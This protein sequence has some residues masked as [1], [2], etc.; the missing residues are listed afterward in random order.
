MPNN[1]MLS[2]KYS[3]LGAGVFAL[4][5]C[6]VAVSGFGVSSTSQDVSL[7]GSVS[8]NP[9][10]KQV[11]S[12]SAL[13]RNSKLDTTKSSTS[14][15]GS[16]AVVEIPLSAP[17]ANFPENVGVGSDKTSQAESTLESSKSVEGNSSTTT[18]SMPRSITVGTVSSGPKDGGKSGSNTD[19]TSPKVTD[20]RD[21]S[22]S[23]TNSPVSTTT[24]STTTLSGGSSSNPDN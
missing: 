4:F 11:L 9:H 6:Y 17:V 2:L 14:F 18:T 23:S 12:Y 15:S 16:K 20:N 5:S 21:G 3:W 13:S 19:K 8:I 10:T 24:T 1:S 7:A 22:A